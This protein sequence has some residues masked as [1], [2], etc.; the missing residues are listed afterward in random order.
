MKKTKLRDIVLED[1]S[2]C[3]S[4]NL[5]K[6]KLFKDIEEEL[7]KKDEYSDKK[8]KS[9]KTLLRYSIVFTCC[10]V[11][12]VFIFINI[13]DQKKRPK[14]TKE[15]NEYISEYCFDEDVG[16]Y[17]DIKINDRS[18]LY[19]YKGN[20]NETKDGNIYY[21]YYFKTKS[22]KVVYLIDNNTDEEI[23]LENN[24]FGIITILE[25][26]DENKEINVSLKID[27]K[28]EKYEIN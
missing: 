24:A 27:G 3:Y 9:N 20:V 19:I 26:K 12:V 10:L 18:T 2:K 25:E 16:C 1:S 8:V 17:Y 5:D 11:A 4:F 14:T 15:F 28:V 22:K 6:E 7:P 23:L 21:F 13:S